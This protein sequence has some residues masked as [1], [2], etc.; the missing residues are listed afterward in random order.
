MLSYWCETRI[1]FTDYPVPIGFLWHWTYIFKHPAWINS[2][3]FDIHIGFILAL[4][5]KWINVSV[6]C[7]LVFW[8]RSRLHLSYQVCAWKARSFHVRYLFLYTGRR[9]S[10]YC[11]SPNWF[12]NI[13][14]LWIG[15]QAPE[16][17]PLLL[18][19]TLVFSNVIPKKKSLLAFLF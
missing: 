3:M 10:Q 13:W 2:N 8:M 15:F 16:S 19:S 14:L 5:G 4:W 12:L 7:S 1:W 9:H 18:Y 11:L 6:H 17:L